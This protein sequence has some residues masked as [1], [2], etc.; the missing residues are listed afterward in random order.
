VTPNRGAWYFAV[1]PSAHLVAPITGTLELRINDKD[2]C[3]GD[4]D[5]IVWVTIGWAQ[6]SGGQGSGGQ[7]SGGQGSGTP[8]CGQG[9]HWDGH[10]CQ[11]NYYCI[12]GPNGRCQQ[13]TAMDAAAPAVAGL[14]PAIAAGGRTM[15][16]PEGSVASGGGQTCRG[17]VTTLGQAALVSFRK[18]DSS[19]D[20]KQAAETR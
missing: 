8:Q 15:T 10:Q 17:V 13:G 6:G 1:G 4:N 7:S 14:Q 3:L 19:L 16:T 12:T 18:A 20:P 9:M 11:P 5:G 2:A